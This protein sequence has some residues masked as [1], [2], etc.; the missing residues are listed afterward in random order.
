M[1]SKTFSMMTG[2]L[3]LIGCATYGDGIAGEAR[4]VWGK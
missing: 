3:L 4:L 2:S 1:F